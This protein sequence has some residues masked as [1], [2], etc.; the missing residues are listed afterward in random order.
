MKKVLFLIFASLLVLGACGQDEHKP[1][2]DDN[3]KSE[4]KSDKKSNDP[5]K[6]KKSDDKKVDSKDE[7]QSESKNNSDDTTNNESESTSKNDNGKSQSNNGNN[8]RI[9]GKQTTQ[10]SDNQQPQNN[11]GYMSQAEIDEWNRTKPT[12]HDESQMGYGRSEYE[13]ARK[14]SEKVW[15]N[16]NA[17]VGG[18]GWVGKN[19]GYESWAK[20]QQEVQNTPAQ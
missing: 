1:N 5:K 13:E 17:H 16:P 11:N 7:K 8:E 20:R 19:E 9:Q 18:P 2:K 14:A 4:S 15:N 6:D 3:K 10:Q 12:T